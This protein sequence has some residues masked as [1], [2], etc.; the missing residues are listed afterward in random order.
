MNKH[1][2]VGVVA[3]VVV[4]LGSFLFYQAAIAPAPSEDE[5]TTIVG[6]DRDEHGCIGSA[7]YSWC[8]V[9]NKCLREWEEPCDTT[10]VVEEV[11]DDLV[12]EVS[13]VNMTL[14]MKEWEWVQ[15][16]GE[17]GE[18]APKTAGVFT[19]TFS[20]EGAVAIGTD[21]NSMSGTYEKIGSGGEKQNKS[22]RR[23]S[24]R[25][26]SG[27]RISGRRISGRRITGRRISGRRKD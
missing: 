10:D 6:G 14:T 16:K 4:V 25:R 9:K 7:G 27:R 5:P 8:E 24:G 23:K 3:V 15:T 20:G 22:G 17:S 19:L 21:C 13:P 18:I 1:T 11:Q 12:V 26:K 2:L